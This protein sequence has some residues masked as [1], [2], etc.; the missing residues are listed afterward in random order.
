MEELLEKVHHKYPLLANLKPKELQNEVLNK[1]L[2]GRDCL[3]ILPTGYGKT[4]IMILYPLLKDAVSIDFN[5]VHD[6]MSY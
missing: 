1:L 2:S 3:G 5:N 4:L 6:L